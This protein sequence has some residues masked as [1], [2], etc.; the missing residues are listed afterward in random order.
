MMDGSQIWTSSSRVS[1]LLS[2]L[3]E[4]SIIKYTI[5]YAH[6]YNV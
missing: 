2:E 3:L 6:Y 1:G 5:Y 4:D